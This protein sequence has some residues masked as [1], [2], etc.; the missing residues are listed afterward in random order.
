METQLADGMPVQSS[1]GHT[2]GKVVTHDTY[3]VTINIGALRRELRLS[4][5]DVQSVSE[6]IVHLRATKSALVAAH[7]GGV[8]HA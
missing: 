4:F 8:A 7:E 5:D 3:G 1:D 2:M 6:G